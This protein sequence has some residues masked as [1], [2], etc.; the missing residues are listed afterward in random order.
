MRRNVLPE[1]CLFQ[2]ARFSVA[3]CEEMR[4]ACQCL[5]TLHF[6]FF[7]ICLP[8]FRTDVLKCRFCGSKGATM[9]DFVRLRPIEQFKLR[10]K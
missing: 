10:D 1:C 8:H 3:Q 9:H 4:C 7:D 6:Y 2:L 5:W